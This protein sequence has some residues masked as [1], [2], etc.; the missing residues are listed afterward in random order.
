MAVLQAHTEG[1]LTSATIM[2]NMPGAQEA[3]IIAKQL[4]NLGVGVH[5]NLTEGMAMSKEADVGCLINDEGMFALSERKL[6]L[7]SVLKSTIRKAVKAEFAAQIQW[8]IDNGIKPTH[9]DSH[10][11]IHSFP[12]IFPMV[13]ELAKSFKI[14]AIRWPF[15]PKQ[16]SRKPW[17]SPFEGG[18]KRA[19]IVRAMAKIN[20]KQN[21]TFFKTQAVLGIAHTGKINIDFLKAAALQDFAKTVEIITHPGFIDGLDKIETRLIHER[22]M[23]LDVLCEKQTKQYFKDAGIKL[24]HYGQL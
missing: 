18:R 3:I 2:A 5:L 15:E 11:H 16:V 8:V 23:E 1:L 21:P 17:P 7:L 13:C 20:R 12:T 10:K 6:S 24:V 22:K 14:A 19:A 4:P 9:L